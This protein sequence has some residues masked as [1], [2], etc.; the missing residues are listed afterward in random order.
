MQGLREGGSLRWR[1]DLEQLMVEEEDDFSSHCAM[2][3]APCDDIDRRLAD[4]L[5]NS[6]C[7]LL[8]RRVNRG[9]YQFWPASSP[10]K[11]GVARHVSVSFVN[12]KLMM[13]M[14]PS[15]TDKGWNNGKP[16]SIEKFVAAFGT[17]RNDSESVASSSRVSSSRESRSCLMFGDG[18][19]VSMESLPSQ[20]RLCFQA[21][22]H[23][24]IR[25]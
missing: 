10:F 25:Q 6:K 22:C 3:L 14:E 2:R 11:R 5:E 16:G 4:F 18:A 1:C 8:F 19:S 13:T 24:N 23:P 15:P 9:W 20:K 12:N 21:I 17:H 7:E